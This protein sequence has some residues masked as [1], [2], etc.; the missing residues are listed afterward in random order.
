MTVV[1][2]RED[3]SIEDVLDRMNSLNIEFPQ[4]TVGVDLKLPRI[5]TGTS[6]PLVNVMK[7]LGMVQAFDQET[8]EFPYFC[9]R[10]V[11][12][13]NM[14][15]KAA[16][17]LD[18]EGTEAAAVTVIEYS[19]GEPDWNTFHANRPFFYT[20][21]EQSTGAIFFVGQYTGP[22]T[23]S[24][25]SLTPSLSKGEGDIYNLSGQRL[26]SIPQHGIYIKGNRKVLK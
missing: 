21:S 25:V 1:L 11:F 3:K 17:N 15:Q 10:D 14:F 12:I 26:N 8:A 7:K 4:W 6:L 9:N 22:D 24:H 18:E 13:S 20:I 16:I 19:T 23:A 2:P 5:Q